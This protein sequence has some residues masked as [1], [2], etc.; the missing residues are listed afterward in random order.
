MKDRCNQ[1]VSRFVSDAG[2]CTKDWRHQPPHADRKYRRRNPEPYPIEE[3][4]RHR[5]S[6]PSSALGHQTGA[7]IARSSGW[8]L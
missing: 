6:S 1:P 7:R 8:P 2:N 5:G 3:P 4:R